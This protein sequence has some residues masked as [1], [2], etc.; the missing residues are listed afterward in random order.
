LTLNRAEVL[1]EDDEARTLTRDQRAELLDLARSDVKGRVRRPDLLL[2]RVDDF[3]AGRVR[4][5]CQFVEVVGSLVAGGTRV[6]RADEDGSLLRSFD[7][8]ES[9][10]TD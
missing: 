3:G 9:V 1:V 10:V 2:K 4:Q 8:D 7:F 5:R 6:R